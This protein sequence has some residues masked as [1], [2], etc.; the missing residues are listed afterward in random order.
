AR[1]TSSARPFYSWLAAMLLFIIVVGYGNRHPWY[2]L[3]LV[4]IFAGFGGAAC[5]FAATKLSGQL[6]K[7]VLSI[8]LVAV[9]GFA[10]FGYARK[11]YEPTAV[12]MRNAGLV[13]EQVTP[14]NARIVAA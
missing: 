9:F 7:V 8:L 12:S 5:A 11:L 4:P 13:L 3:P 14:A 6:T 10:A 2:Q 1:S